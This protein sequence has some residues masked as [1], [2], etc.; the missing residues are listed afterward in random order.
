MIFFMAWKVAWLLQSQD[1]TPTIFSTHLLN[2]PVCTCSWESSFDRDMTEITWNDLGIWK[3][4]GGRPLCTPSWLEF[5]F[6]I[7]AAIPHFTTGEQRSNHQLPLAR[8]AAWS[9]RNVGMIHDL[10]LQEVFETTIQIYQPYV[11]NLG[12]SRFIERASANSERSRIA[13]PEFSRNRWEPMS[14]VFAVVQCFMIKVIQRLSIWHS[15]CHEH[16]PWNIHLSLPT[17]TKSSNH[18]KDLVKVV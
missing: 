3:T 2:Q 15:M 14:G 13:L 12:N 9:P 4:T 5:G 11:S 7:W 17:I 10:G 6:W 1:G 8:Q 18:L 16:I